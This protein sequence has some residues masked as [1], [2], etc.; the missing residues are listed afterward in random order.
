M[1]RQLCLTG[2]SVLDIF[3]EITYMN[4]K[5]NTRAE[6]FFGVPSFLC[7]DG[8]TTRAVTSILFRAPLSEN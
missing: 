4:G 7:G 1:A 2:N 5:T 6:L 3:M 8:Q